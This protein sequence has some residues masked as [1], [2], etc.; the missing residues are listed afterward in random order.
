MNL[1]LRLFHFY[2]N[3]CRFHEEE[4][5]KYL[6]QT[7]SCLLPGFSISFLWKEQA[8]CQSSEF[9]LKS[10]QDPD[11]PISHETCPKYCSEFHP[12]CSFDDRIRSFFPPNQRSSQLE[13][14]L[15]QGPQKIQGIL[16]GF[17]SS[18]GHCKILRSES[19]NSIGMAK[20]LE[21]EK[22]HFLVSGLA[23]L[24]DEYDRNPL[25]VGIQEA[26]NQTHVRFCVNTVS[27]DPVFLWMNDLDK[28]RLSQGIMPYFP[29]ITILKPNISEYWFE[30]NGT[31]SYQ[32]EKYK[33]I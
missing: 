24:P 12:S 31:R 10:I 25:I 33:D 18:I 13:E 20:S 2:V 15:I 26:M 4:C 19:I 21:Q 23:F 1:L 14:I 8:L 7:P 16:R 29:C 3:L 9:Q 5:A 22:P 32:T 28:I 17:Y 6:S 30:T 11:C 27:K